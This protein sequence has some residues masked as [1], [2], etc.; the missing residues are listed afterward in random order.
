MT[1]RSLVW[2]TRQGEIVL[3][4]VLRRSENVSLIARF[5]TFV[6][7]GVYAGDLNFRQKKPCGWFDGNG[8]LI[9]CARCANLVMSSSKAHS[10]VMRK[11]RVGEPSVVA[12]GRDVCPDCELHK[13]R[14]LCTSRE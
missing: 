5:D 9:K 14:A 1:E 10:A 12:E 13:T 7:R 6:L 11:G 4:A 2:T 3:I 8:V